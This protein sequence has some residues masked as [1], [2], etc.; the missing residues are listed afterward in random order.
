MLANGAGHAV[1]VLQVGGAIRQRRSADRDEDHI[2][3][4]DRRG[5]IGREL[6]TTGATIA[7][8]HLLEARL[9]DRHDA[10]V[11]A[12]DPLGVDVDAEDVVSDLREAGARNEADVSGSEDRDVHGSSY[13]RGDAVPAGGINDEA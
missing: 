1:D 5:A 2:A 13:T 9:E 7:E 6:K 8:H 3:G 11:E 4:I 12:R 10:V